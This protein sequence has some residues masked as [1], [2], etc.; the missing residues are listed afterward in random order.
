M[1][2]S[3]LAT[4]SIVGLF[5][6]NIS[7]QLAASYALASKALPFPSLIRLAFKNIKRSIRFG[8][9]TDMRDDSATGVVSWLVM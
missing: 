2:F 5:S 1:C 3:F 8:E 7:T 9:E 6:G 4:S